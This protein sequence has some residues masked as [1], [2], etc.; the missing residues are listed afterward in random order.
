MFGKRVV[1]KNVSIVI[2][3][4]LMLSLIFNVAMIVDIIKYKYKVGTE[5]YNYLE[6]IRSIHESNAQLLSKAIDTGSIDNMELLK[7]YKNY[8][9]V[10]EDV[11]NLWNEYIYYEENKKLV[12]AKKN[13]DTS[14]VTV[15]DINSKLEDFFNDMLEMEMKT[16]SYKVD[17]VGEKL[18]DF[19]VIHSLENE[20][21]NYYTEFCKN[22]L[23]GAV[24]DKKKDK[25][26]RHHY[27]MDILKGYN[28]IN[29]K[30]IDYEFKV[31]S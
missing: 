30:Y 2:I 12:V 25:I 13:I 9:N 29:K 22:E 14:D 26:I 6:D 5:G 31:N 10:T 3:V 7:L 11:A 8:S 19:K 1:N 15:N 18:E 23:N 21:L 17:L 4:M 20:K 28:D 24:Q 16:Q 27:W